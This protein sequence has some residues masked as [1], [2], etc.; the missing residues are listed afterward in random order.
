MANP[1]CHIELHSNNT[2]ESKKFY[3]ELFGWE[4]EDMPA[5]DSTYTFIKVGE[6]TG[7]GIT[8][9]MAPAGTPPHWLAYVQVDDIDASTAK[10]KELGATILQEPMKVMEYGAMSV[11]Q[12]PSGA[13]FAMW[14][15]NQ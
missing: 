4:L 9:N 2:D 13:V 1:F 10:A 11:I 14:K 7:G 12:D 8:R 3:G 6:G 15:A 5:G